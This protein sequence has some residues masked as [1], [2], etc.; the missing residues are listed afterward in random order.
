[1]RA[2]M[3]S[4]MWTLAIGVAMP[5]P[6]A[7]SDVARGVVHV[8]EPIGRILA[9]N[10][11]QSG[12]LPPNLEDPLL[13][14][15]FRAAH[16]SLVRLPQDLGFV[17]GYDLDLA[18]TLGDIFP[19]AAADPDDPGAYRFE[20]LDQFIKAIKDAGAEPLW[21]AQYD[22]GQDANTWAPNGN[23]AGRAPRD[24][25]RWVRVVLNVLRHLN[26]G[27]ADGHHWDVRYVEFPNE[28]CGLGGYDCSSAAPGHD[29]RPGRR[30]LYDDFARLLRAVRRY[31][32]DSGH[33]VQVAGLALPA[34]HAKQSL[35]ELLKVLKRA[36][37]A[38]PIFSYHDYAWP[39]EM[40]RNAW[41][42]HRALDRAG[43][44]RTALWNTEW[45]WPITQPPE[46]LRATLNL[47]EQSAFVAAH[48]AQVKSLVQGAWDAGVVSRAIRSAAGS[49]RRDPSEFFYFYLDQRRAGPA[50]GTPKPAYYGWT[51]MDEMARLTP[52]RLKAEISM[53]SPTL[54]AGRSIDGR[55]LSL[56]LAHFCSS[57]TS[58]CAA[59]QP[60]EVR[61]I[62]TEPGAAYVVTE[63]VLDGSASAPSSRQARVVAGD[64]ALILS[65]TI[66]LWSVRYLV[67]EPAGS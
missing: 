43:F 7:A 2:M 59:E 65:G 3:P 28:P 60:Y 41:Q 16:V 31:N 47:D 27:W 53:S 39:E 11:V 40:A 34:S 61:L 49:E 6:V 30:R 17:D 1:M 48:N 22:I 9:L 38:L 67:I 36:G 23:Q 66:R 63:E 64:P 45:N 46:D 8:D 54:L 56:L 62:G 42:L 51:M 29:G 25:A 10:G 37:L 14:N 21:E 55:R 52:D 26:D 24:P 4:W 33:D 20:H 44:K 35:P 15:A 5:S 32:A 18:L 57:Y 58:G 50:P 19:D 12:P 13:T